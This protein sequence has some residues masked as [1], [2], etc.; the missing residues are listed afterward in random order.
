M[1]TDRDPS[2]YANE[3]QQRLLRLINLMAGNEI[4]GLTPA[5]IARAQ[6]CPA[7]T[8]I[9]DLANL[10]LAGFAEVVPE[11][12]RWRLSPQ[13]VQI[14]IKHG[15]ALDRAESKLAEVRQRFSRTV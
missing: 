8:V 11:T 10:Q 14:S 5:D 12:G 3:G 13:I 15:L 7:P 2:R 1:S 9:R 4:T 6:D